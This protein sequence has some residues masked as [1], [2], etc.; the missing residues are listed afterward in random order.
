M[1]FK[2]TKPKLARFVDA[3]VKARKFPSAQAVVEEA[4]ARMMT[5]E[6]DVLN[7]DDVRA[8]KQA[9]AQIDRGEFVD[10]DVFAA[11]ARKKHRG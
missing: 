4:L 6:P 2:L 5:D 9:D 11:K 7:D 3:Q 1:T 8:I 10:F